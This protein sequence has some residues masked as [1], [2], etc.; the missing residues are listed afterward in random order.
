MG[1]YK[2]AWQSIVTNRSTLAEHGILFKHRIDW[3][4]AKVLARERIIY[5]L[6]GSLTY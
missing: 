1:E 5:M 6:F 3:D 4:E 2:R